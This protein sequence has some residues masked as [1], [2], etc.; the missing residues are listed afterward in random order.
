MQSQLL[1]AR[2]S[3][4]QEVEKSKHLSQASHASWHQ[5]EEM[6]LSPLLNAALDNLWHRPYDCR[7]FILQLLQ[8]L[9]ELDNRS[10]CMMSSCFAR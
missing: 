6:D 3:Y 4:A 8:A 5:H 10:V 1:E 2:A 7:V 9:S